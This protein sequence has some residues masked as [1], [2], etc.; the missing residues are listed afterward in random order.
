MTKRKLTKK[1]MS[2]F[3]CV[4]LLITYIPLAAR[5]ASVG[6]NPYARE[7]DPHTLD[8]WKNYFGVQQNHP[9]NVA[10]STDYAGAVW[11]D[12]SVFLPGNIPAELTRAKYNGKTFS[13][14]D[15]GDNFLVALSAISSN[16]QITGY[17]TIP[18]DT[19]L[20][21]DMSSSMRS[22][23]DNG[24]SAVDELVTAA[25][26]AI[27]RLLKLN[28]NNRIGVVLYAGNVNQSFSVA[29]GAT[30][31]ILPLDI[32][33]IKQNGE[34]LVSIDYGRNADYGIEVAS[35]V[36]GTNGAVTGSK[37][38]ATGTFMQDGIYEAMNV[39]LAADPIVESGVQAGTERLPIMVLMSDGEPTLANSDY[40]GNGSNLGNSTMHDFGGS[41]GEHTHRDTI[42]FTTMLTA[43]YAKKQ[44][45]AHY[46]DALFYTLAYGEEVTR[47]PEALSV[48]DP[49]NRGG[50]TNVAEMWT[51]FLNDETVNVYR[52]SV[53]GWNN[54][55]YYTVKNAAQGAARLAAVDKL[56]VDEYFPA[57]SDENFAD[58]FDA[59]VE[60][61]IIQSK[62]YPTYVEFDHDHD[63]YLT[64]V[65]KIGTLMQVKD[66]KG[67]VVGDRLFS[68]AAMAN[69]IGN[70]GSQLGTIEA[71][72]AMG[73]SFIGSVKERLGI[74]D[75]DVAQALV[76]NAYN[77]KQLYY[78]NDTEFSHYIGWFADSQGNYLDFWHEGM[79]DGQI[80]DVVA[81]EGATHI[82]K[83]YGFLGDTR[84]L[85]G[86]SNT[87]MMYMTVRIA[88]EIST[89]ESILTW[90][91]PAS[92]IPTVTYEVTVNVDSDGN[93]TEVTD[94]VLSDDAA[95]APVRLLYEAG[96]KKGVYDWNIAD[97]TNERTL[98]TNKWN[99]SYEDTTQNTYSHFEPS[100]DNERY[101][102]TE[103]A[104]V[105]ADQ[106]GT[107]Y[108]GNKPTGGG[109]YYRQYTVY[110]KLT[111]G[112]VRAHT[113]YEPLTAESL[114]LS[115]AED[116][117]TWSIPKGTVHRYYDFENTQKAE[118]KTATMG[119]SDHPFIIA[120]NG[121]YYTYST[122]GNN[123]RL[124]VTAATGISLTKRLSAV[125][126]GAENSFT[127]T[128]S[129]DISAAQVVRLNADGTEASRSAIAANG[130][131]TLAADETVYIIGLAA[132]SYTV[133]EMAHQNYDL[134]EIRLDGNVVPGGSVSVAAGDVNELVF[135]NTPK[136]PV[137]DPTQHTIDG[138][139]T[140]TGRPMLNS[141]FRFRLTEVAD[142]N[143][144][145]KQ[146]A[147]VL[148]AENGP[149]VANVAGFAFSPIHYDA[150]GTHYYKL[151]EL[152]GV[153]GGI[154][155]AENTYIVKVE[156][157][158]NGGALVAAESIV[159]SSD[160]STDIIFNNAYKPE[161][162]QHS[163]H[164]TKELTGRVLGDGEFEFSITETERD[165][166]TVLANGL[167]EKVKNNKTGGIDFSQIEFEAQ[168]TR[169]FVIKEIP[170]NKGGITYD[171]SEYRLIVAATDNHSG[172]LDVT[173]EIFKKT[174]E[175]DQQGAEQTVIVPA[176]SVVF[177]NL[178]EAKAAP[179]IVAGKKK[180][181]NR[182]L[183]AD[184]FKFLLF[185]ADSE[186]KVDQ[187][188]QPAE[189]MNKA[190]GTFAFSGPF[191]SVGT[192]YFVMKEDENT[193]AERV[194]N[195]TTVYN[196]A[197]TIA[198]DGEGQLYEAERV[199]TNAATG[200]KVDEIVFT[201]VY[202]PI[203][204]EE[205]KEDP[206]EEQKQ[207]H[208]PVTP[209]IPKT[210][211][212]TNLNLWFALLF[213]SGGTAFVVKRKKKKVNND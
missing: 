139:K 197:I 171:K 51:D 11:T 201:N 205:P 172:K 102:F 84:D 72:T 82:I 114:A 19:V 77:H 213:V 147:L 190:D 109:S 94:L 159:K 165:F 128:I 121:D 137:P 104:F 173:T 143:G 95:A 13:V 24:Q 185:L 124:N 133:T 179:V 98:Y 78:K 28:K 35:G 126:E 52:Y 76:A 34:Y 123:G 105:Y 204:T 27:D 182:A 191:D 163:I 134:T 14:N 99:A 18:T 184:E 64:F 48:M 125:A 194:T 202:T 39:F 198:D 152:K 122:Q 71:P 61:I 7:T 192:F 115:V 10:L 4:A 47:L 73:H 37:M 161:K 119:Y 196:I 107:L 158:N 117:N 130:T 149:A 187:N 183:L 81:A 2:I 55:Q 155:Y 36:S 65:D 199:I 193:K 67:I 70:N 6:S 135:T 57:T 89:G 53:G 23:D 150:E 208:P 170:G 15:T 69:A 168:G 88:T 46:G 8:Q 146:N 127:F 162:V 33:N 90:K 129:G 96:L 140:L 79:T 110:E 25:N 160:N 108:K 145:A 45:A 68:G 211:E 180:L 54:Y 209:T 41:T 136:L 151:E 26:S 40:D 32:Y 62:Y 210:G 176:S 132:G 97:I 186:F 188:A 38:T 106:N 16:K 189:Q 141:E 85:D 178:Y 157:T 116:G 44:I 91:L 148:E 56:Y 138:R 30:E 59:I 200:E 156:V 131:V 42:A 113:H 154:E 206:K 12:K 177:E 144:A 100:L 31:T 174:V 111:N 66:V 63:G 43:A 203:P 212:A 21:L 20:V 5:G 3:L 58:A 50:S 103:K 118:N 153:A 92:L 60:E 83:S 181:E 9:Q 101:Y 93:I 49:D 142:E 74:A 169:Y 1:L 164:S 166:E 87:D 86:I 195:D 207:E 17:S 29:D 22:N 120:E 75:T 112:T 80:A 167:N 175:L